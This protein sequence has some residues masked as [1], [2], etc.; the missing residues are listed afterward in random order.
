MRTLFYLVGLAFL[1]VA[2][3]DESSSDNGEAGGET[4]GGLD[5]AMGTTAGTGPGADG[6]PVSAG[7]TPVGAGETPVAAGEPPHV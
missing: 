3:G 5:G 1:A 7:G 4:F 2:C 6:T